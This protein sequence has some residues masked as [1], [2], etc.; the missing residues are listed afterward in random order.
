MADF[1][2]DP[3]TCQSTFASPLQSRL[4]VKDPIVHASGERMTRFLLAS[5]LSAPV[6]I[7]AIHLT[8]DRAKKRKVGGR[9]AL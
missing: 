1:N 9:G 2:S 3:W 5:R 6:R 8:G 4:L 7:G